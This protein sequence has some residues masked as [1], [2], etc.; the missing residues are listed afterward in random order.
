L[1]E[2]FQ[3]KKMPV[4]TAPQSRTPG[5]LLLEGAADKQMQL[6]QQRKE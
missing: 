2:S 6:W 5:V 1:I 3:N 4:F